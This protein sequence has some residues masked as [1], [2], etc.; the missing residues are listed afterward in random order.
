MSIFGNGGG[1]E[2]LT[3]EQLSQL[4]SDPEIAAVA[5]QIVATVLDESA[6]TQAN[7]DAKHQATIAALQ[8]YLSGTHLGAVQSAV[9]SAVA[10]AGASA[11]EV[12]LFKG[13]PPA[14]W[15]ALNGVS[16]PAAVFNKARGV[17]LNWDANEASN[18]PLANA[19]I[20]SW[21]VLS[22]GKTIVVG[23]Q[24]TREYDHGT[25]SIAVKAACPV[26]NF[27]STCAV[28]NTLLGFV[29][30]GGTE[31]YRFDNA[32]NTWT[33]RAS[34]PS[35]RF[36]TS[37]AYD[38]ATA[39]AYLIG[40]FS[41]SSSL[42]GTTCLA[43][44]AIYDPVANTWAQRGNMPVRMGG[45]RTVPLG[46]GKLFV[47]PFYIAAAAD[48]ANFTQ[49]NQRCWIYDTVAD[50]WTEKDSLPAEVATVMAGQAGSGWVGKDS[51]G[52]VVVIPHSAPA[53][54]ARGR[55]FNPNAAAGSQWQQFAGSLPTIGHTNNYN[56]A[57]FNNAVLPDNTALSVVNIG[58]AYNLVKV[59]LATD[60]SVPAGGY[61]YAIKNN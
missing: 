53:T 12:R 61:T 23:S 31:C 54:G 47:L 32:T 51:A 24:L 39:K 8:A 48:G 22:S 11:G 46:G 7:T 3:P 57:G 1:G 16:A 6:A 34:L 60:S 5:A 10:G 49:N 28:G 25:E 37:A 40:G 42:S 21:V 52:L 44:L 45:V 29:V 59:N 38:E 26:S 55:T 30:S 14:G 19:A 27:Y 18:Y 20:N 35:V 50:T 4:V 15:T 33:Q 43:S 58:T 41:S 17:L 2:G 13:T 56:H 9:Q 36:I